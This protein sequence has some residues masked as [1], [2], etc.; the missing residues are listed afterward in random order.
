MGE[1]A[2]RILQTAV[3]A[4]KLIVNV[5]GIQI[6]NEA[7]NSLINSKELFRKVKKEIFEN[8]NCMVIYRSSITVQSQN[9]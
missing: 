1:G 2:F 8:L 4:Y 3:D 5:P 7:G 9:K 6:K